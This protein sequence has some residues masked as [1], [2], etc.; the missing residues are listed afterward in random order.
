MHQKKI[1]QLTL[2][3][4]NDR[5]SYFV[6]KVCDFEEVWG[7]NSNGWAMANSS[8][9]EKVI[10]FWPEA[11]F[12]KLMTKDVWSDYSAQKISLEDFMN[13]WLPGMENDNLFIAIF[14][15]PNDEGFIIKPRIL[16]DKIKE[17]L[18][19]YD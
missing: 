10:P 7:L 8:S 17:E 14:P 12:S 16:L 11:D 5:L 18:E 13:K 2:M 3:S 15:V 6:R 9:G 1:E 19:Q 4:K